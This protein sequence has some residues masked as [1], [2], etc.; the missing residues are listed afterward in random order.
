MSPPLPNSDNCHSFSVAIIGAG[1]GG[2]IAAKSCLDAGH[3][4]VTIF[5]ATPRFGGIWNLDNVTSKE[6][7][8]P[9]IQREESAM[10]SFAPSYP[11]MTLNTSRFQ[12]CFPQLPFT[13][14]DGDF[15]GREDFLKY[16]KRFVDHFNLHRFIMF[17]CRVERLERAKGGDGYEWNV[18]F[19][20]VSSTADQNDVQRLHFQRVVV[21][22]GLFWHP[23]VPRYPGL[24]SD[25]CDT[26]TCLHSSQIMDPAAHF[27]GR[28]V[29]F[30]GGSTSASD[31]LQVAMENDVKHIW[32]ACTRKPECENVWF[33]NIY[34]RDKHC[35]YD[36]YTSQFVLSFL[37]WL[38]PFVKRTL[39]MPC[40][41]LAPN[42]KYNM[43]DKIAVLKNNLV[44]E[45][46]QEGRI[47]LVPT[48]KK[49]N[50]SEGSV[51]LVD[52][53]HVK[54]D[55]VLF[56]TG[57]QTNSD[58]L[59]PL[60][61]DDDHANGP[62]LY[63]YL[64]PISS[65]MRGLA[66]LM[67]NQT[68]GSL[69]G[70]GFLEARWIAQFWAGG[71]ETA[72][73]KTHWNRAA[74]LSRQHGWH[75]LLGKKKQ[76]FSARRDPLVLQEL[77]AGQL[78]LRPRV[79]GRLFDWRCSASRRLGLALLIGPL[80]PQRYLLDAPEVGPT[81]RH[82]LSVAV[83]L[84]AERAWTPQLFSQLEVMWSILFLCLFPLSAVLI[85]YC[86]W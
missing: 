46:V 11:N 2:L 56:C 13:E 30:V 57:Y 54:P 49:F 42:A 48:V 41:L 78:H 23:H 7:L 14:S 3:R 52:D 24:N 21:A 79:F 26:V 83:E 45:A 68:F 19:R 20:N 63:Q 4:P 35:P 17:N 55:L 37:W 86:Y 66:F 61:E 85:L 34:P 39:M 43:L 64:M 70:L 72:W 53:H 1:P 29:L 25:F 40:Q 27:R 51:E 47:E 9:V 15:V 60:L 50:C 74:E 62:L 67:A 80:V 44:K 18:F 58:L 69:I 77:L 81:E 28:R 75:G 32:W 76:G 5:E 36:M 12:T 8:L 10:L 71:G 33:F 73:N 22:V 84:A 65:K 82:E 31:L 59:A 38:M 16:I 6:Q